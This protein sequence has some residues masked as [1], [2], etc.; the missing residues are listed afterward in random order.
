MRYAYAV[1]HAETFS[2]VV[3][4]AQPLIASLTSYARWL[5]TLGTIEEPLKTGFV[6]GCQPFVGASL[7]ALS[8]Q[9]SAMC[10]S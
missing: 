3:R 7:S 9:A 8:A 10:A 4:D 2:A 6:N 1:T 5:E